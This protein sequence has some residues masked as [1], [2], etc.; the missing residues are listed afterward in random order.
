MWGPTTPAGYRGG[1]TGEGREKVSHADSGEGWSPFR[2]L[3]CG[4]QRRDFR[5]RAAHIVGSRARLGSTRHLGCVLVDELHIPHS[6]TDL[7]LDCD[8][9]CA[10]V[11][12]GIQR[13][14]FGA[15]QLPS[16][17]SG[18]LG[19]GVEPDNR[20]SR[21]ERAPSRSEDDSGRRQRAR[22]AA[23]SEA[24]ISSHE[25]S[26][27]SPAEISAYAWSRVLPWRKPLDQCAALPPLSA[28]CSGIS[29]VAPLVPYRVTL[30]ASLRRYEEAPTA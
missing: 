24:V 10:G 18:V 2:R 13:Q 27:S 22:N 9:Q 26:T 16:Q 1:A 7:E 29:A 28:R 30:A 21:A 12:L 20:I 8:L 11:V 4:T 25:C 5:M 19:A 15:E 14:G 6:D 23:A 17:V 3:S